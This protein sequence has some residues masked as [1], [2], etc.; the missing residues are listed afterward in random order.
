MTQDSR[1]A[2]R[3]DVAPSRNGAREMNDWVQRYIEYKF[4]VIPLGR[5]SKCPVAKGWDK[6]RYGAGAFRN[7]NVGTRAGERVNVDGKEGYLMIVDFDSTDLDLLRQL[8]AAVPLPRTTCVR[9]GGEHNGYHLF[10]LTESG[11]R[12]RGMLAYREASVDLLGKGSFAVVPPSVVVK[13][14]RYLLGLDELAFLAM[15]TYDILLSV[16]IRWK[17]TNALI[18]QAASQKIEFGKALKSLVDQ[19]A[20]SEMITYFRDSVDQAE[21]AS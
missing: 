21:G 4:P 17:Q 11:T 9:T 6:N 10:Y 20:T 18:K 5:G 14:Y 3:E 2:N 13:P 12:K 16:L 15:E 19:N 1:A 8:C 7:G